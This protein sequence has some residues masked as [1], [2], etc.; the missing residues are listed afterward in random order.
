MTPPADQSREVESAVRQ[1]GPRQREAV[2]K[3]GRTPR[4]AIDFS[5]QVAA[6]LRFPRLTRDAITDRNVARK[7]GRR[8][9]WYFLTPFGLALKAA[10]QQQDTGHEPAVIRNQATGEGR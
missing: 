3:L 9:A 7:H 8:E 10:L 6:A 1:L 4:R 5:G 2:L